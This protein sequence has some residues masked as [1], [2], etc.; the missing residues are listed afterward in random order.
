MA[1]LSCVR[2]YVAMLTPSPEER[3]E[4]PVVPGLAH[5]PEGEDPVAGPAFE[6][7]PPRRVRVG[8]LVGVVVA[9]AA[10]V[11]GGS[12]AGI[13]TLVGSGDEGVRTAADE[14]V[15]AVP[16]GRTP[17]PAAAPEVVPPVTVSKSTA[18]V[19]QAVTVPKAAV[20]PKA[21]RR[22]VEG[23]P[24]PDPRFA[25]CKA[26]KSAGFGPYRRGVDRE[27]AWYEDTDRDGVACD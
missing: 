7:T 9:A 4:V 15:G 3:Y 21:K 18:A 1:A 12:L 6:V 2:E 26:A 13:A 24:Q 25:T 8:L 11:C 5:P 22:V 19:P 10:L 16:T 20:T 27:Y 17:A 14:P 23:T